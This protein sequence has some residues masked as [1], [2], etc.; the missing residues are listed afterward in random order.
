MFVGGE[1]EGSEWIERVWGLGFSG[2]GGTG[3]GGGCEV[4]MR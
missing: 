1:E 4:W 3:G 2:G